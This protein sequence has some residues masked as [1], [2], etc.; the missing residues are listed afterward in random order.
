MGSRERSQGDSVRCSCLFGE[1]TITMVQG[2]V[3]ILGR[4]FWVDGQ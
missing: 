2:A 1:I 3:W 4:C